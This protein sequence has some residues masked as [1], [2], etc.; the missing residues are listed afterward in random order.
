MENYML[1]ALIFWGACGI[2]SAIAAANKGRNS[3]GWFFIGFLLGPVGLLVSLIIS[4]DNTQIE[5]SAIQ[6]GECK[7]CPDCAETIKFE[8]IK[9]KHCGYVFSS[10]NDSVRAQPKPFPL[11]YEVWQG[12]WANAVDLIDQ[13]ADVN[14]KNLDG[15]TPLELAKMRGDN[16]I[17]EMLTSKGALEN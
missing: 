13:G 10:Q 7:K 5:F 12:N 8:A 17:I 1:I 11:H 3:V 16:L 6:R 14:E 2:G 9:C 15:R 4:S